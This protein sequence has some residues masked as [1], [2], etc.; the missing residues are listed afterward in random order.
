M[1]REVGRRPNEA[2]LSSGSLNGGCGVALG[3][4]PGTCCPVAG[5]HVLQTE[6]RSCSTGKHAT[7]PN[8]RVTAITESLPRMSQLLG[9]RRPFRTSHEKE[10]KMLSLGRMKMCLSGGLPGNKGRD[11]LIHI[12][13][14]LSALTEILEVPPV[15]LPMRTGR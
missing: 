7:E 13:C 3:F 5:P 15:F 4:S 12:L 2:N 14:G 1:C 10:N 11:I 9:L 8:G 6:V